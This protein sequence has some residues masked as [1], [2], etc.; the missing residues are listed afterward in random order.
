MFDVMAPEERKPSGAVDECV[1]SELG[2]SCLGSTCGP[3]DERGGGGSGDDDH[4]GIFGDEPWHGPVCRRLELA[5]SAGNR[6]TSDSTRL[7]ITARG[8]ASTTG[9]HLILLRVAE[10]LAALEATPSRPPP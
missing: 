8:S 6:V 5:P 4:N 10:A 3:L 2:S 1:V 7:A 9:R